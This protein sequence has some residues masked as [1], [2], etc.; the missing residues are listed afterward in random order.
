MKIVIYYT[1]LLCIFY[2]FPLSAQNLKNKVSNAINIIKDIDIK[3][4]RKKIKKRFKPENCDCGISTINEKDANQIHPWQVLLTINWKK[5][6]AK[7]KNVH[8]QGTL[9]SKKHIVTSVYCLQDFVESS[10]TRRRY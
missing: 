3:N 6:K 7:D 5:K 8:C 4:V 2:V 1:A 9:I 10:K